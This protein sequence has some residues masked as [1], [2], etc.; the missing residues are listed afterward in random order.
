MMDEYRQKPDFKIGDTFYALNLHRCGWARCTVAGFVEKQIVFR[1]YG[2][3]KQWWH[4]EIKSFYGFNLS[5]NSRIFV[6][7]L[8][9]T[10]LDEYIY[11]KRG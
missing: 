8:K 10:K 2:K 11:N 7:T 5:F 9:E 3:H 4:Y 6:K 1:F